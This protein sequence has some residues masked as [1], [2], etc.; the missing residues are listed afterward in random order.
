M[1]NYALSI[2]KNVSNG[3]YCQNCVL[4]FVESILTH[5]VVIFMFITIYVLENC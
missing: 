3:K 1:K 4:Y 5:E 2:G